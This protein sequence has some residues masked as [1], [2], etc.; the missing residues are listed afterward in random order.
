MGSIP[1][2]VIFKMV[3]DTSLLNTQQYKVRIKGKVEQSRERSS[4]LPYTRDRTLTGTATPD[5]SRPGSNGKNLPTPRGLNITWSLVSYPG[6]LF[7]IPFY[8]SLCVSL[9]VSWHTRTHRYF[10][11]YSLPFTWHICHIH[12]HILNFPLTG[13]TAV[14]FSLCIKLLILSTSQISDGFLMAYQLSR[15]IKRQINF[16]RRTIVM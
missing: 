13:Q 8:L 12:T 16:C 2:R 14:W 4:A 5:Q 15:V 3:L 1:R 6:H 10:E 7:L 11:Q 9:S